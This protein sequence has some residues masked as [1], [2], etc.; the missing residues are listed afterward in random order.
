MMGS[1]TGRIRIVK[2]GEAA[3]RVLTVR[4]TRYKPPTPTANI[5]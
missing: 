1:T 5:V 4:L 3:N 2:A